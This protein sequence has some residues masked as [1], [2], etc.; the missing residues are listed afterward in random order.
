LANYT[1]VYVDGVLSVAPATLTIAA[2]D[3]TKIYGQVAVF[4]PTE[5]T[6]FGLLN[7]DS[8]DSVTLVSPGAPA[9][10]P[11]AG[12]P[13][14][15][16][17]SN[18][19]GS[20]LSNYA[21]TYQ[22]GVLTVT[23]AVL[24]VTANDLSKTYGD[25]VTFAGTEF[26]VAG[27][28]NADS[29]D[30]VTLASPGAAATA[31]VAGSPY[32]IS[33]SNAVGTGLANYMIA[34]V[35]GILTVGKA[36]ATIVVTGYSVTY[37]ALPHTATGTATG[38]LADDLSA[39]LDL[40][41]TTHTDV[42]VYTD[43][44]TFSDAAGNYNDA[45][46]TVDSEITTA[47][48]TVTAD[49]ASKTYGDTLPFAGTEF[50]SVGLLGTDAV[51]S[52]TL[53][54]AGAAPTATVAGS[55]YP[56]V[57]SNAIG[58]GL[59]N[60]AIVYVDGVLTVDP[61]DLTVTADDQSKP[62]GITFTF[63]G[64]E[65][66]TTG[67]VNGDAVSGADLASAGALAPAA[68]GTYPITISGAAGTGLDNYV[69]TYVEGTFTVGNTPPVLDD[70][71]V[72]TDATMAVL[73]AVVITDPDTGQTVTVTM[74]TPPTNGTATVAADGSF[75]YQP[76]G[77]FTGQDTFTVQGCD[78][79]TIPACDSA[80]VTVSVYPVAVPD[81][82]VTSEGETVEVD[83]Q[84]NDIGDA[85]APVIVTGPDHGTARIGSIIYTPDPGF[86]GTDHVVYRVCSPNDQTLCDDATL[87]ITVASDAPQTDSGSIGTPLGP[88]RAGFLGLAGIVVFLVV[89]GIAAAV[90]IERRR[91]SAR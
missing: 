8:I 55:P 65:L 24:T 12:S 49:S 51:D 60:Y 45:S 28:Q 64:T 58:S 2:N 17:P 72:S 27:L 83:V 68:P 6:P 80:T 90:A 75:S 32:L 44:W 43:A 70:V 74:T 59:S 23:P 31:P 61:A 13:Y 52:V 91:P 76:T 22:D 84:A 37:D 4:D 25:A 53:A 86:S 3:A 73:G 54:S 38:V 33:P 50:T 7:A 47:N 10:A 81:A 16:T 78:D 42:G 21:I 85:G 56:I 5:F 67:L 40:T 14:P 29:V 46:G 66:S 48:L 57:A 62:F 1:I 69:I 35:D 15:I 41:A 26:S 79:A 71:S 11:V 30:S 77:T 20:G 9:T 63:T 87:T 88:V 34:Y 39:D 82:Q 36:D 89:S 19:V 18:A